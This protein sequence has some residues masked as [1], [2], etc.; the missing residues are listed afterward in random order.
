MVCVTIAFHRKTTF[1][2]SKIFFVSD[3]NHC[4][5]ISQN[6]LDKELVTCYN[7]CRPGI[8][9][10]AWPTITW[11]TG[12]SVMNGT[13]RFW[14]YPCGKGVVHGYFMA[15]TD[16][17]GKVAVLPIR[18]DSFVAG[19][20]LMARLAHTFSGQNIPA[21]EQQLRDAGLPQTRRSADEDIAGI[22]AQV[23]GMWELLD[24]V[25]EATGGLT[26]RMRCVVVRP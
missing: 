13:F 26:V 10:H 18:V 1:L 20:A 22:A 8:V 17:P 3:K 19:C 21:L 9:L 15:V 6:T 23:Q 12:E 25:V 7:I 11:A 4:V 5:N 24:M 14:K 2:A 16:T